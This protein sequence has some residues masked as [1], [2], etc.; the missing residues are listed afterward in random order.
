MRCEYVRRIG[1]R[2]LVAATIAVGMPGLATAQFG[3]GGGGGIGGGGGLGGGGI[4]GGGGLGGGGIGGGTGGTGGG[5]TG[6]GPFSG[7]VVDAEGVLHRQTFPDPTGQ[8]TRQR[9]AAA[10]AV[11]GQDVATRSPLRKV[12]LNRLEAACQRR[13]DDGRGPTEAMRYLAGLTRIEY[14]FYYPDSRDVVIAGPAEPFAADPSGRV[15]GMETG[16]AVLELQDL[17]VALRAFPPSGKSA[18]AIYCS[19]DPTQE[20]LE[21]MQQFLKRIGSRATPADTPMIVRGLRESLGLQEITV[22]GVSPKTHF[23][24]VLVEADYLMKLIGIGLER[25]PIKLKSYTARTNPATVSRNALERW[26]FVP[27]YECVRVSDDELAMQL[28][29]E[30]VK[31]ISENEM[32]QQDGS[33]AKSGRVNRASQAFVHDFTRKYPELAKRM[34]VYAQLRNVIDMVVAA[35]FIQEQD[36]YGQA[37]WSLEL[38]G[39]EQT[40]SVESYNSPARVATAVNSLWK[41]RRL[42]T[43]V[44]GG[45]QIQAKLAIDSAN[46]LPDE[47]GEV[48]AARDGVDTK[49]LADGQWWWD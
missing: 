44:G 17:I 37:G 38:F 49:T 42:V 26:Y 6:T 32:V 20:G 7:V 5:T 9:F 21:R 23:A 41:G 47:R 11:L 25:P 45:V 24:Q 4:G 28:V 1:A 8:L 43:P 22:G 27:N 31:L 10:R 35:A 30:G 19:I 29:G 39:S 14:V 34:P 2:L 16:H 40:C 33:R 12:S 46:L 18:P 3:G 36:Y 15:I 48:A 13:V